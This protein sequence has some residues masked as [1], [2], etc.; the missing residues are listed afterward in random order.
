[1]TEH[2]NAPVIPF[3]PEV[4]IIRCHPTVNDASDLNWTL[5]DVESPWCFLAPV[6][7]IALHCNL[8]D[9][10]DFLRSVFLI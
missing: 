10:G 5:T 6:T 8:H 4:T 7:G 9:V 3:D 1:V 2:V